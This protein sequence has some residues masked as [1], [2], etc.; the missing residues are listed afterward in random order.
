MSV[1][2]ILIIVSIIVASIFVGA[3]IWAVKTGQFDDTYT[4]SIR[5]LFEDKTKRKKNAPITD[6]KTD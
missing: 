3:F 2:Y 4:P 6:K 5:M 1:L